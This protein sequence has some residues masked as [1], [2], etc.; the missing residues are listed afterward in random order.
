MGLLFTILVRAWNQLRLLFAKVNPI[1]LRVTLVAQEA[2][3]TLARQQILPLLHQLLRCHQFLDISAQLVLKLNRFI[4]LIT[5]CHQS[6]TL[7]PLIANSTSQ[8][9]SIKVDLVSNL[10]RGELTNCTFEEP[11]P[12]WRK[13]LSWE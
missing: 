7:I 9:K 1:A 4:L 6:I 3:V 11:D 8:L 12:P 13:L 5:P 2:D 10:L